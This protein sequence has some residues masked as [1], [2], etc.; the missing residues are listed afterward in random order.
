LADKLGRHELPT[1][2]ELRAELP[3]TTVGKL[4]RLALRA[5]RLD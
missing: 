5:E 3:K 1:A 2:L 4:S